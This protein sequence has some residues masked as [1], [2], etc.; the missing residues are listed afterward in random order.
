LRR[1]RLG[2]FV[3][4]VL[5]NVMQ[6]QRWAYPP[7]AV[8]EEDGGEDSGDESDG[9]R[10]FMGSG[11][12]DGLVFHPAFMD[13]AVL[14]LTTPK[15]PLILDPEGIALRQVAGHHPSA[16]HSNCPLLILGDVVVSILSVRIHFSPYSC[17]I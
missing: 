9:G 15:W 13:A 4:G 2:N 12:V 14:T 8:V 1:H 11:G 10:E 7:D 6:L 16:V 17:A 5:T 3:T